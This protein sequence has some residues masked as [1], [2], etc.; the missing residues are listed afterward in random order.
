MPT[1]SEVCGQ[2]LACRISDEGISIERRVHIRSSKIWQVANA[3][4]EPFDGARLA[5]VATD[6]AKHPRAVEA[7]VRCR[8]QCVPGAVPGAAGFIIELVAA[9][10]RVTQAA[11]SVFCVLIT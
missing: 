10:A 2:S 6:V 11:Q 9:G 7:N 8:C 5:L 1:A 4:G 3:V